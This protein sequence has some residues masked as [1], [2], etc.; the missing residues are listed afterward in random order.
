M[1]C[2][3]CGVDPC[4]NLPLCRLCRK[5]D[6]RV[7]KERRHDLDI[8]R[9]RRLF[10]DDGIA[11]EQADREIHADWLALGA[12][13]GTIEALMF[14]LRRGVKAPKHPDNQRRLSALNDAQMREVA[15]RVQR[16]KRHIAAAWTREQ[17]ETL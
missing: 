3:I 2:V 5:A 1:I 10:A 14:A 17:V 7:R 4:I 9:P 13:W 11:L 6:A 16:F 12:K 8:E 15:V